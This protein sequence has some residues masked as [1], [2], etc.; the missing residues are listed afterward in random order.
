MQAANMRG[1]SKV[2]THIKHIF[3]TGHGRYIN[4]QGETVYGKLPRTRVENPIKTLMRP[5]F[6]SKFFLDDM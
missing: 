4:E 2:G 1:L 3:T 5:T 6:M